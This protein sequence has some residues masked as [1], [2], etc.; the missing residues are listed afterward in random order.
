MNRRIFSLLP[1][2]ILGII[3]FSLN[4]NAHATGEWTPPDTLDGGINPLEIS[5]GG[6]AACWGL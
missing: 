5:A 3:F 4:Y 1:I 2:L 6:L